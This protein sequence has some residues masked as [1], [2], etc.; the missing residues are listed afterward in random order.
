MSVFVHCICVC[1]CVCPLYMLYDCHVFHRISAMCMNALV[2]S[3]VEL[4]D[5]SIQSLIS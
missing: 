2:L 4:T 3:P 5:E 1:V